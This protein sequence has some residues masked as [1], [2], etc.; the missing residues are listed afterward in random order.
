M[1]SQ[2]IVLESTPKGRMRAAFWLSVPV[3]RQSF[4]ADA[5]KKSEYKNASAGE[6]SAITSGA[7]TE[8]VGEFVVTGM[9][10]AQIRTMLQAEFSARQSAVNAYNPWV[11]YGT[12]WDGTTWTSG[13]VA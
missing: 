11:R 1:A 6:L 12:T 2:I 3:A 8:Q 10:N 13:G 4:Y 5:T 9:A 7:V